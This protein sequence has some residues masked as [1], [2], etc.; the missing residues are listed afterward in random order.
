MAVTRTAVNGMLVRVA[1][2]A[3][4]ARPDSHVER[5]VGRQRGRHQIRGLG[6][7][8]RG[9]H[10]PRVR[11]RADVEDVGV[12]AGHRGPLER[13]RRHDARRTR[14]RVDYRRRR[15]HHDEGN[16]LFVSPHAADARAHPHV[17]R[18]VH[19]EHRRHQV[20]RPGQQPGGQ[21]VPGVRRGADVEDVRV[22]A[23]HRCPLE[24]TRHRLERGAGRGIDHRRRHPARGEGHDHAVAPDAIDAR[25]DL[26]V[27]R[28]VRRQR[29]PDHVGGV[30]QQSRRQHVVRAGR[31]PDV[32]DVGVGVLHGRPLERARG[33]D[34][35]G[36]RRG[37]DQ[38][39]TAGRL[40]IRA[41]EPSTRPFT[42]NASVC[43]RP[44]SRRTRS[45]N[46]RLACAAVL[47]DMSL[48]S[49]R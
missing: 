31:R 22:G 19:R 4:A 15:S 47:A 3:A 26:G 17:E 34:V 48:P 30:R 6:Q 42:A 5:D 37:I 27:E 23:G 32:E 33:H 1:P 46:G 38:R 49:A 18:A 13:P 2:H 9:E 10:I 40:R 43:S 44:L 35:R 14:R 39:A 21:H 12:G 29:R 24:R 7:Q 11:R 45:A 20:R 41:V 8:P 16:A 25:A 28:A 36:I